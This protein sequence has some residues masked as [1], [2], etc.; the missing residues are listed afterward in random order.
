MKI[1]LCMP[2]LQGNGSKFTATNLAHYTKTLYPSKRVALVDFDTNTPYL[3]ER[4]AI[5]DTTHSIDNLTDIIDGNY[6]DFSLF[7]Q[8]MIVLKS[9]VQLLK[10]TKMV[11]AKQLIN[12]THI[13]A[14]ISLL[15]EN[16]D[17][18]FISV[19]N[20][21]SPGTV[22]GLF[23]A[24]EILLITRNNYPNYAHIERVL[25]LINNYKNNDSKIRLVI[26]QYSDLSE[27]SF[28]TVTKK[29]NIEDTELIP[30]IPESFDHNDLD[31][32]LISGNFFKSKNKA[33]EPF[34]ILINKIINN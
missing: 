7:E 19:S 9:G 24:D 20:E 8:N 2:V 14:I 4:L 34:E 13:E 16:Y 10:G 33:Q 11:G 30:Y 22:Y 15:K 12:K 32:G 25:K 29:Y 21:V 17:Y 18:V 3:A 26:N 5:Q 28:N 27:V 6:L 31:K 1:I 23:N